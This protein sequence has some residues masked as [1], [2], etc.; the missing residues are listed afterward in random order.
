MDLV[1]WVDCLAFQFE[2]GDK[3]TSLLDYGI[4]LVLGGTTV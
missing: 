1:V 2:H 4:W 3:C